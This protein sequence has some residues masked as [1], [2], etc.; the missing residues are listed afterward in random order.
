MESPRAF[1]YY[2]WI[3]TKNLVAY[4]TITAINCILEHVGEVEKEERAVAGTN[5]FDAEYTLPFP[6]PHCLHYAR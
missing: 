4:I 6:G 5:L 1:V 3:I 2:C